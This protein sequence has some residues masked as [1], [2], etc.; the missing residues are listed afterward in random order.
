MAL[1]EELLE[2]L[3]CPK[4]KGKLTYDKENNRLICEES[5]LMY[6]IEDD[7]PILL[8]EEAESF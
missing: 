8:I 7:I 3:V 6:R 5:R 1:S 4:C 2:V